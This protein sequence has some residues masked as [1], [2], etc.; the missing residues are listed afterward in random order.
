MT[1]VSAEF[2]AAGA[3]TVVE[4]CRREL[5]DSDCGDIW[6][7]TATALCLRFCDK[8]VSTAVGM[9]VLLTGLGMTCVRSGGIFMVVGTYHLVVFWESEKAL[10]CPSAAT[11][12]LLGTLLSL[13][14]DT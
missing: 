8:G 6:E 3:L 9:T 13:W 2:R 12:L 1:V 11:L 14:A 10:Y 7:L 5:W 4:C